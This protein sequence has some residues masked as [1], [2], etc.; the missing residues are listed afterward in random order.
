MIFDINIVSYGLHE[1]SYLT[2]LY[3]DP[4]SITPVCGKDREGGYGEGKMVGGVILPLFPLTLH[5]F[6]GQAENE[7]GTFAFF[8]FNP[9][10]S[11]MSLHCDTAECQSNPQTGR[12]AFPTDFESCKFFKN[13]FIFRCGDTGPIVLYPEL[14]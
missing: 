3:S 8:A 2:H 9:D 7:P 10:L 12:P 11:T 4:L 14:Y 13:A 5:I 6:H 1:N